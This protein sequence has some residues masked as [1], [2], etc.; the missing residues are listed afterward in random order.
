MLQNFAVSQD[1]PIRI[2]NIAGYVQDEW[3]VK[4][5]LTVTGS[6]RLEHNSNPECADN[7][8]ATFAGGLNQAIANEGA[9]YN[10]IIQS[11]RS[12]ALYLSLIHI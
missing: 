2:N 8:F 9:P 12:T 4:S 3:R 1:L 6:L 5:N 10:S 11:G 7:C